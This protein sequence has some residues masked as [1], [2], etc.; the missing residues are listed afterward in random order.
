MDEADIDRNYVIFDE[1]IINI[2]RTYGLLAPL[3]GRHRRSRYERRRTT[4][5]GFDGRGRALL[6]QPLCK[7]L[8][9]AK[10]RAPDGEI[11]FS[12]LQDM[13]RTVGRATVIRMENDPRRLPSENILMDAFDAAGSFT[14]AGLL[15]PRPDNSLGM[16][17]RG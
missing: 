15:A 6:G 8:A 13:G 16:G 3:V 11:L 14:G 10:A 17:G 9:C 7:M 12:P 1:N 2:L 4:G 5:R